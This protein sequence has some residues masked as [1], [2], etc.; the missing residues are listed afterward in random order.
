MFLT[1]V[2]LALLGFL[3]PRL[4]PE[5]WYAFRYGTDSDQVHIEAEPHDCDFSKAPLGDKECHF[6]KQVETQ[7][8][9]KTGKVSVYVFWNKVDGN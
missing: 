3:W 1:V 8:D 5:S 2:V 4:F 6:E 7:T 9:S